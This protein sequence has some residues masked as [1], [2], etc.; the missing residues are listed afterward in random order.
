[1]IYL[2]FILRTKTLEKHMV[3]LKKLGKIPIIDSQKNRKFCE[4]SYLLNS[5]NSTKA[6]WKTYT[7]GFFKTNSYC[8]FKNIYY[9]YLLFMFRI[10]QNKK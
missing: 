4:N 9:L 5:K 1:M 10:P 8:V 7:N 6:K 3:L 2:S